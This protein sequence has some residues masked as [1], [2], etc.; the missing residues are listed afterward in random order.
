MAHT[1]GVPAAP[2]DLPLP[3]VRPAAVPGSGGLTDRFGRT[4]T[5]LRLSLT[6][7][8]TLRCTYCMPADGMQWLPRPD[9]LTDE[10]IV[11]LSRIAVELLGVTQIRLTGGEPLLRPALPALVA[12]LASLSPRPGIAM[13]TNGLRLAEFAVP[14]AA[15]GL[16]RV[17]VSLDTVRH[18]TFKAVT[19]RDGLDAVRAGLD[20]AVAAGLTPV[21][22]NA[23]L[24]RDVNESE[25]GELL[26]FCLQRGFEL[27]FIEA[28]PLDGG[29]EWRRDRMIPAAETLDTLRA[30]YDLSP[31]R[32]PDGSPAETYAINGGPATVGVI[33]SVTQPFCADCDRVR[34]TADG[35]IR[36][37]L[38]S[39]AE[40]DL[41]GPLR[42]GASDEE[43]ADVW[44]GA[45]YGKAARHGINDDDFRPPA[46]GMSAIGG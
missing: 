18:E 16:D 3:S 35:Q 26:E 42:R 32:R 37:C 14:L 10:E 30:S 13:T 20:A 41:R 43:L 46:R 29:G 1:E 31:G 12:R 45:V 40:T 4:A 8:C 17:N 33:A 15:A 38:F 25:A 19:R 21:K 6:D 34:L 27:R 2:V 23:V 44:R 7:R 9:L 39:E 28:M 22:V 36:N 24:I 11:R 5:D